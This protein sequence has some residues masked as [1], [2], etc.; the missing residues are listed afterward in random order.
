MA[1]VYHLNRY[2]VAKW[3]QR[4]GTED[5]SHRPQRRHTTLNAAQEAG[6]VVLRETLLLPLDDLL[7]VTR[8]S[9]IS[10]V[11]R[12]GVDRCLHRHGVS[13]LKAL[14]PEEDGTKPPVK[15]FKAYALGFVHVDVQYL[16][17]MPVPGP[18]PL[19]ARRH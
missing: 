12:S 9:S 15:T 4:E 2:T 11:S 6:V 16:P 18:T 17:Q 13:N 1:E 5:A 7:A 8:E 19:P 10:K 3:R 14:R